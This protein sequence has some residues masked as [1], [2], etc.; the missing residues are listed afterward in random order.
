ME[1]RLQLNPFEAIGGFDTIDKLVSAF[2]KRVADHPDLSPIFPDDLTETARKQK[3]FLTQLLGGPP[4]YLEEHGHP[5]LRARHLRFTITPQRANAW[6]ACMNDALDEI[7]IEDSWRKA[8]Y[9]RLKVIA[10]NMVNQKVENSK[11][12]E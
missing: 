4:L 6:L 5:M 11:K 9:N 10:L 2:Y 12:G 1:E 7:D 3:Q 8:I